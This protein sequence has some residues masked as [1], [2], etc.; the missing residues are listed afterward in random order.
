MCKDLSSSSGPVAPLR[1][2]VF[3]FCLSTSSTRLPQFFLTSSVRGD[4]SE[5]SD[6][7]E[8]YPVLVCRHAAI[9]SMDISHRLCRL[10]RQ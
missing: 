5:D 9:H 7:N 8:M 3:A 4:R 10:R 6:G 2:G 1:L